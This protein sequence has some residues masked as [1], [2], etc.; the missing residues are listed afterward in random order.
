MLVRIGSVRI[1]FGRI[2][3]EPDRV[4]LAI[5]CS[6]S[7]RTRNRTFRIWILFLPKSDPTHISS[8]MM[9]LLRDMSW[10]IQY[11]SINN[12]YF[13]YIFDIDFLNI[14]IHKRKY[15]YCNHI[16]TFYYQNYLKQLCFVELYT[17]DDQNLW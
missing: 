14:L 1:G 16:Y 7:D 8:M 5:L 10:H 11:I 13:N 12:N 3:F 2:I 4:G 6:D 9:Y 17:I 15:V